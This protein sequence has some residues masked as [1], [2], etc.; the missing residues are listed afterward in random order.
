MHPPGNPLASLRA[1]II[2]NGFIAPVHIEA[3][4]RNGIKVTAICGSEKAHAVAERWEIPR[5][6][7]GYD[8]QA[9]LASSEVD[10]VHITSPNRHHFEQAAA[11]LQAGKHLLCEKPLAMTAAQ[12]AELVALA[13]RHP[14][15]VFAVN[16][17]IRFFPAVL[18]LRADV[19]AGR[20]G[21]VIH[22]NGSFFQDWL[23]KPEDYNW[24]VV[25]EEGGRLRAVGDIGTHWMDAASFILGKPIE[26]VMAQL[27]TF[28]RTRRRPLGEV[29]TFSTAAP[30]VT[31]EFP[32][33]TEDYA[34]LLFRFAGGTVGNLAVSQVAAGRKCSLRIEIYGSERSAWW[35]MEQ[36][37]FLH[38]GRR[39]GANFEA[40]RATP[41]FNDFGG[42]SDYPA[43]HAEGFGDA[44]KMHMRAI[45]RDIA[46]EPSRRP[47]YATVADGH[48]E[49]LLCEAIWRSHES[50]RWEMVAAHRT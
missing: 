17:N 37:D 21:Q 50:Q 46:G 25:A 19:A 29:E 2:G 11:A 33:E 45:Y 44:C 31:V 42:Y 1:G 28:H 32:V 3:L 49:M 27:G 4:R 30:A 13:A 34:N 41:D 22:V 23:L 7:T 48:A 16:Y 38:Y 39:D 20:L 26:S 40:H 18:Q 14:A 35:D 15:Q 5:V 36:P 8:Y 43:G 10:A 12:G 9:L 6:F 47:L 24:R